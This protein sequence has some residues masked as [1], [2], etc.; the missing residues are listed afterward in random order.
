MTAETLATD[1]LDTQLTQP[2]PKTNGPASAALRSAHATI[3]RLC[4]ALEAVADSLP[5]NVNRGECRTLSEELV[6]A[7]KKAQ[8]LEE[9]QVFPAIRRATGGRA[10]AEALDRLSYEH[11][12]DLCFAEEVTDVLRRLSSGDV[13][14]TEAVGYMLRGLFGALRRH[15]SFEQ[16][17]VA[18]RLR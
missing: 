5:A 2:I 6:P 12:E 9:M 4:D 17:L 10:A 7:L 1:C 18:S 3:G 13:V 8:E 16:E 11:F 14:N 15:L